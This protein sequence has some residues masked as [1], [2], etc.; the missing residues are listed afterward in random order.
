MVALVFVSCSGS[1]YDSLSLCW[2]PVSN[3]YLRSVSSLRPDFPSQ[4]LWVP[5]ESYLQLAVSESCPGMPLEYNLGLGRSVSLYWSAGTQGPGVPTLRK[6]K[7]LNSWQLFSKVLSG[8]RQFQKG[9]P[10]G[11][12]VVW[13]LFCLRSSLAVL[14]KPEGPSLP[15]TNFISF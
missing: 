11:K 1:R 5:S 15:R 6:V 12:L 7:P 10:E 3:L 9:I 13:S 4:L 8:S 2:F 14:L